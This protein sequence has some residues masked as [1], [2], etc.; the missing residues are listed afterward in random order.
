MFIFGVIASLGVLIGLIVIYQ[1]SLQ[2]DENEKNREAIYTET[3]G[4]RIDDLNLTLP[5]VRVS[6]Y[7]DF[8]VISY[9]HKIIFRYS[10]ISKIAMFVAK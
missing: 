2:K 9:Y 5:F 1:K 6:L 7:S 10:E 3:T 8:F 4:A